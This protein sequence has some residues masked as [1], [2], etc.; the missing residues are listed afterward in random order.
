MQN[1][2]DAAGVSHRTL[3]RYFPGRQELIDAVGA[4]FDETMGLDA[5]VDIIRSFEHWTSDIEQAL[6]FGTV[7]SDVVGRTLVLAVVTGQWRKDR[8][9]AY[10]EFFR[11][12]FVNLDEQTAREDFAILRHLLWSSNTVLIGQRFGLGLEELVSA[13][14]RSVDAIVADIGRRDEIARIGRA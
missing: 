10:W 9:R 14:H 3:Y 13:L 4:A 5:G 1:V 2:A 6:R 12:R 8:D 11:A 7:H